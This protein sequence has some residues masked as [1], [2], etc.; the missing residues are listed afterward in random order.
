VSQTTTGMRSA[1]SRPL[2]Y[3]AWSRIVGGRTGR[4]TLIVEHV[5]PT[6]GDRILDL[7]CGPGEL[8]EHLPS[9]VSY[10]GVDISAEYIVRARARARRDSEFRVGDA[11]AIDRDLR[12]FDL[13]LAFGVLHHLD[14]VQARQLFDGVAEALRPGGRTV[15]VD[16]TITPDQSRAARAIITRDRGQHVRTPAGYATLVP[17][18]FEVEATVRSDVLRIPYTH[19]VMECRL[20]GGTEPA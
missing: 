1:L 4:A 17:S 11:T 3:E 15:T 9:C 7:G 18:N 20:G 12:G 5:R 13:V 14:D 16:P 19:S 10:V 2:V 8:L 6:G